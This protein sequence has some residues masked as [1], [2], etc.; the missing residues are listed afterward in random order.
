MVAVVPLAGV[1]RLDR[2]QLV[3][4]RLRVVAVLL[5]LLDQPA[6]PELPGRSRKSVLAGTESLDDNHV[7]IE[8]NGAEWRPPRPFARG[9]PPEA[10][11]GMRGPWRTLRAPDGFKLNLSPAD[12]CELYDL[13]TDPFEEHN[14]F[15][16]PAQR[17][18]VA[19]L[20]QRLAAWQ[21]A[22]ADTVP[23]PAPG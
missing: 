11:R 4:E 15:D 12:Q 8:W 9:L 23:L 6:A 17:G 3:E 21:Q 20:T 18:R 16:D 13:N 10:F 1:R 5:D 2:S 22:A 19:A 14:L 7:V